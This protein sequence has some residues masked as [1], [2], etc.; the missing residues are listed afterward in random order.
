MCVGNKIS[1]FDMIL[2]HVMNRNIITLTSEIVDPTDEI[3][4]HVV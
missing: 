4:F 2:S 1:R 3:I